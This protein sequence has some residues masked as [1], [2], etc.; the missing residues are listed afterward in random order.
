V[1]VAWKFID[2]I[3]DAW[4]TTKTDL[5]QYPAGSMGPK[6]S[7]ELLARDGFKWWPIQGQTEDDV[8]WETGRS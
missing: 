3:Q 7:D 6:E 8:I 1:A 4:A 2:R 5:V